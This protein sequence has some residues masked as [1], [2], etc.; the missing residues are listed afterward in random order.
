MQEYM[1]IK[2]LIKK[3]IL[4]YL[5]DQGISKYEF[6]KKTGITRGILD[7]NNGMS[8]ENITKFLAVYG[9][10]VSADLL[11]NTVGKMGSL[12]QDNSLSPYYTKPSNSD[13]LKEEKECILAMKETINTQR[14][15]IN[16]LEEENEKL[17]SENREPAEDG[18]KK[19]G[20]IIQLWQND[21]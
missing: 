16:R 18:A 14:K 8:E 21:P 20:R 12:K 3:S 17:K 11:F 5:E 1:Q 19:K 6:Y 10:E 9:K 7:Q 2:S 13:V 4:K 15:Y